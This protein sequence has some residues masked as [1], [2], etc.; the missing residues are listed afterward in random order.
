MKRRLINL[1]LVLLV[2]ICLTNCK[3]EP[4]DFTIT[5]SR[6]LNENEQFSVSFYNKLDKP[7]L[8]YLKNTDQIVYGDLPFFLVAHFKQ[9]GDSISASRIVS[10]CEIE[11]HKFEYQEFSKKI[12]K[13]R[14][15]L[16]N[17]KRTLKFQTKLNRFNLQDFSYIGQFDRFGKLNCSLSFTSDTTL[18]MRKLPAHFKKLLNEN[19]IIFY[20]GNIT[21]NDILVKFEKE[22][23]LN[24]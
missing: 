18:A 5:A 3:S 14:F 19:K 10:T 2:A 22:I 20:H 13:G 16:I 8:I 24:H 6:I 21:S 9:N 4:I 12:M 17:P 15:F 7:V 11:K 1:T 23:N